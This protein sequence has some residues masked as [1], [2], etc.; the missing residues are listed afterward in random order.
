MKYSLLM[1]FM[2]TDINAFTKVCNMVSQHAGGRFIA[3][4]NNNSGKENVFLYSI[5]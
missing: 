5:L 3:F 1:Y 4:Q 2:L